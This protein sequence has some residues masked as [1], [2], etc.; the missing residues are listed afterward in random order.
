MYSH[1][2]TPFIQYQPRRRTEH[3]NSRLADGPQ[4]LLVVHIVCKEC[5]TIPDTISTMEY[6]NITTDIKTDSCKLTKFLCG[7]WPTINNTETYKGNT[8]YRV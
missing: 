5:I 2:A 6:Y 8:Y 3:D 1:A 7:I 4:S